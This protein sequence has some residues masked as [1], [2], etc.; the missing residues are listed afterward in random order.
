MKFFLLTVGSLYQ[1]LLQHNDNEWVF[2]QRKGLQEDSG[3]SEREITR[4]ITYDD[5]GSHD[6]SSSDESSH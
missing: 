2:D 3:S 1:D 6:S 5:N 4:L